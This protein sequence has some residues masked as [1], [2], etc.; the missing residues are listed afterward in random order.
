M[1]VA[2]VVIERAGLD[3]LIRALMAD[4]YQVIGP[5]VQ[6]GSIVL[7]E[8]ESSSQLTAGWGVEVTPV[9]YRL[10]RREDGAVFA[11]SAGPQ[12]WKQFLYPARQRLWS[13]RPDGTYSAEIPDSPHYAFLGVR[14]CDLAALGSSPSARWRGSKARAL[15]ASRCTITRCC[16][17]IA[18]L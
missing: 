15:C 11:H 5:T 8:L 13:T 10:H 4:G 7:A 17:L 18:D 9:H 12:S 1:A 2:A 3:A 14:G 16:G 6:D